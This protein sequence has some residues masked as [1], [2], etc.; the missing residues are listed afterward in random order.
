MDPDHTV[1]LRNSWSNSVDPNLIGVHTICL[2]TYIHQNGSKN[3]QQTILSRQH[4]LMQF[5]LMPFTAVHKCTLYAGGGGGG[6]GGGDKAILM[7]LW[8]YI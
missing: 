6:G 2:Y 1:P 4:F 3:M 8:C 7:L 5:L